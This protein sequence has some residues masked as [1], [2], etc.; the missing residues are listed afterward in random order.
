MSRSDLIASNRVEGTQV[1]RPTGQKIGQVEYLGIEKRS[2]QVRVVVISFGGFLGMG[3]EHRP[4]PWDALNYN[5]TLE[6]YVLNAS[7]DV[8]RAVPTIEEGD[9][10]EWDVPY[11]QS[12]FSILG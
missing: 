2:G 9:E 6:G 11:R 7:D 3:K 8:L 4:I 5:T 12:V 1:Y 10:I